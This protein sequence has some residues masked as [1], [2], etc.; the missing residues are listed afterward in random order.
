MYAHRL[1]DTGGYTTRDGTVYVSEMWDKV[2]ALERKVKDLQAQN[3]ALRE[4]E[5]AQPEHNTEADTPGPQDIGDATLLQTVEARLEAKMEAS[6]AQVEEKFNAR[7]TDA[8][9]MFEGLIKAQRHAENPAKAPVAP[10]TT[11]TQAAI[12]GNTP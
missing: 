5:K 4:K 12:L 11:L 10:Q 2:H 9:K 6:T 1:A 8:I 7:F 3:D